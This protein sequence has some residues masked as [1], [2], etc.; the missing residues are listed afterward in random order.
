MNWQTNPRICKVHSLTWPMIAFV[1]V[2]FPLIPCGWKQNYKSFL[3]PLYFS[4]GRK[5][6]AYKSILPFVFQ[7]A[8]EP[9]HWG[10]DPRL[11]LPHAAGLGRRARAGEGKG[12]QGGANQAGKGDRG[13]GEQKVVA[14]WAFSYRE[15]QIGWPLD[16]Q[17]ETSMRVANQ[18]ESL[19]SWSKRKIISV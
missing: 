15:Y 5:K 8:E 13:Q 4:D 2:S 14:F 12:K 3:R 16:N 19:C 7:V 10:G 9:R 6:N 11:Q 1:T 17:R 18:C